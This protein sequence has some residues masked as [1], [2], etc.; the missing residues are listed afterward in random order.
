MGPITLFDESFLQ[1]ISL[2]EAVWFDR[3]FMPVVCPVFY[4][5]TLGDLGKESSRLGAA[6]NGPKR[7]TTAMCKLASVRRNA[8]FLA[9]VRESQIQGDAFVI[10]SPGSDVVTIETLTTSSWPDELRRRNYP[11][12]EIEGGYAAHVMAVEL[13][14]QFG[15]AAHLIASNRPSRRPDKS[16][17]KAERKRLQVDHA[18]SVLNRRRR[19][20]LG[21][22]GLRN[23]PHRAHDGFTI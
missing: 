1:A 11:L 7:L 22:S 16:L 12:Q 20:Y 9:L 13:F 14:F 6:E 15:L 4:V 10:S 2:D 5:E 3:F 21:Q 17:D 23:L 8:W 19:D 18:P